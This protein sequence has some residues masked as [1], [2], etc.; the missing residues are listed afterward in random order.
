MLQFT[1]SDGAAG[2]KHDTDREFDTQD[3]KPF[4]LSETNTDPDEI[5]ENTDGQNKNLMK[6][7]LNANIDSD[8]KRKLLFGMH[9]QHT[10]QSSF[11]PA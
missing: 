4:K 3:L 11:N 2:F 9:K 6:N 5:V 10:T 7:L 8:Y 1:S